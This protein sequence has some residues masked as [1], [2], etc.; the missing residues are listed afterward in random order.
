MA[1]N[2]RFSVAVHVLGLLAWSDG[3]M[4]SAR[5]ARSVG[6]NPVVIRRLLG[7]LADAGLVAS[8]RGP[9]GGTSL[10]REPAAITL[11]DVYEAS[12]DPELVGRHPHQARCPFG[13]RFR[14][15]LDRIMDRV[16]SNVRDEL[17][18]TTLADAL[19]AMPRE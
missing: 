7:R 19:R 8:E 10:A 16:E 18:G 15:G 1:S 6:T 12:G 17:A 5:I 2:T 3:P 11:L 14:P 4:K 9:A 13:K